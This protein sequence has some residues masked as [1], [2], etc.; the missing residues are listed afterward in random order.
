MRRLLL[1]LAAQPL[2]VSGSAVG[3]S[4][5]QGR[6]SG[7][8]CCAAHCASCGE[9]TPAGDEADDEAGGRQLTAAR[10]IMH[11][12]HEHA[13]RLLNH[14]RRAIHEAIDDNCSAQAIL[15]PALMPLIVFCGFLIQRD[16]V[17]PW[18]LEF[19]YA[20]CECGPRPP[21]RARA[22]AR[23]QRRDR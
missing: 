20:S 3:A 18:F 14:T 9:D 11:R 15:T 16:N 4:C 22:R 23:W 5:V 13:G 1:L 12:L 2:A 10:S 21:R 6:R 7:A 17:K 19:W 8:L